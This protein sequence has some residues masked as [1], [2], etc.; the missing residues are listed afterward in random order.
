MCMQKFSHLSAEVTDVKT[1]DGA[2]LKYAT[3]LATEWRQDSDFAV[4]EG[5]KRRATYLDWADQLPY[6]ALSKACP[7]FA[8]YSLVA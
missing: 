5:E 8:H 1:A 7:N 6:S 3:W 2:D 4:A